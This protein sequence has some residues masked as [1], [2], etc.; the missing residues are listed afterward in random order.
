MASVI[1]THAHLDE[2]AFEHDVA[3]IVARAQAAGVER[4]LTIGTTRASSERA[5]AL[6]ER[7]PDVVSAVV[8]IQPNYVAEIQHGD[9]EA[10]VALAAHPRVVAIG[11]TGLDKYWD[12]AP[13]D[14][15]VDYFDRH[16][17][18][19]R[20]LGKPFIVHC[21]EAEAETVEQ[22]QRAAQSGPLR[23]VMHSF[24]GSQ[25]TAEACLALGM[26]LSFAGM[27][28]FKKNEALREV[29][30]RVPL[31][32]LLVETDAP[33][34]APEPFRGKRN[35]PAYVQHTLQRLAGIHGVTPEEMAAATTANA[36][37]LFGLK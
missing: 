31:D 33:Y 16:I 14:L 20:E 8:G 30:A 6:A 2:S 19:S 37:R 7:F 11:E 24:C 27:L 32:R 5:V 28:T 13:F 21:R 23:G 3:E 18:L 1:D 26:H 36:K 35:E 34:L 10:V 25:T 17:A 9:W 29:A 15:Q 12:Y 4:V 22:L